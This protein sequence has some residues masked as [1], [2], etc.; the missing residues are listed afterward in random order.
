MVGPT[1]VV[2]TTEPYHKH[3]LA[4]IPGNEVV[5][6]GIGEHNLP[7]PPPAVK[8]REAKSTGARPQ[9]SQVKS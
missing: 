3:V 1:V 4:G 8:E 6:Y 5:R 7:W 2:G 9:F